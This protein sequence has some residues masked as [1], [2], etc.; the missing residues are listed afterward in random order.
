MNVIAWL[1]FCPAS[2]GIIGALVQS[3]LERRSPRRKRSRPR[4]LPAEPVQLTMVSADERGHIPVGASVLSESTTT[5]MR[6]THQ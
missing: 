1:L 3:E 5:P 6:R 4:Q 2:I